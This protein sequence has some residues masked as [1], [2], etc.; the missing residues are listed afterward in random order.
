M[1]AIV[2]KSNSYVIKFN[3]RSFYAKWVEMGEKFKS[4]R[5]IFQKVISVVKLQK[6]MKLPLG[7]YVKVFLTIGLT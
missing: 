6:Y 7:I 4:M 3:Q 2:R 1:C 5:V